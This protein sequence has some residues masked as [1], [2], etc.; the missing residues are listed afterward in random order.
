MYRIIGGDQQE[1]GPISEDGIRRWIAEG[2]LNSQSQARTED[3][4]EWKP[5]RLFPEFTQELGIAPSTPQPQAATPPPIGPATAA[6]ATA[7]IQRDYDLDIGACIGKAWALFQGN[8][9]PIVGTAL[10]IQL[11]KSSVTNWPLMAVLPQFDFQTGEFPQLTPVAILKVV[12]VLLL[13][14]PLQALFYAGLYRY[15]LKAIRNEKPQLS[16]AFS[17]FSSIAGQ[18]LLVGFFTAILQ[19]IASCFCLL[20]GIYLHVAWAFAL[21]LVIDRHM[22]FWDAMELS[23]RVVSRHWF[24][25]LV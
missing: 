7:I 19:S 6:S 11:A 2:R 25:L 24:T 8:F 13:A 20:P 17:G 3:S 22:G 10:L 23:R 5:L 21:P 15:F 1:Y 12:P 4:L 9:W 14:M 16:D 18:V